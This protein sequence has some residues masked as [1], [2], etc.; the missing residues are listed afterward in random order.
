[1][2]KNR[3]NQQKYPSLNRGYNLKSRQEAL[4]IDYVDQLNDE[5]K[6]WLNKFNEE[7]VND[8]L[9]RKQ[10][11]KNLHNTKKLIKDCDDRNNA[12]NR[13]ILTRIKAAGEDYTLKESHG[14]EIEDEIIKKIDKE[15]KKSTS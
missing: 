2:K 8:K 12:R 6:A 14:Y 11:K 10:K 5:E 13:D 9:N 4:E 15:R 7:F 1:M 3:R